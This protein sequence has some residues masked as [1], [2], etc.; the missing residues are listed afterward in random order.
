MNNILVRWN[1]KSFVYFECGVVILSIIYMTTQ[2][3]IPY[4]SNISCS[5]RLVIFFPYSEGFPRK[6]LGV[7]IFLFYFHY[8]Y[9]IY[10]C[11]RPHFRNKLVSEPR[12]LTSLSPPEKLDCRSLQP[13][14][15]CV[16]GENV[17]LSHIGSGR[18]WWSIYKCEGKPQ[19]LS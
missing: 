6:I 18:G 13:K 8:F 11:A 9:H 7:V 3:K 14:A 17:E 5:S 10:F 15:R 2:C 4:Y 12:L 1:Q 16:K 19:P